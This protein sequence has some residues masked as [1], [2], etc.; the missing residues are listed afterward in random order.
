MQRQR[1]FSA[2][3]VILVVVGLVLFLRGDNEEVG[4]LGEGEEFLV[5]DVVSELSS[6][7]GVS[8]PEDVERISLSDVSGGTGTGL[9]TRKFD[10]GP[11]IH[12]V[13]A[14]LPDLSSGTF[15]EGWLVRGEVG[16]EDYSVL[17]TG[18]LRQSKGGYLLEFSSSQD[19]SDHSQVVV[20][21]ESMDDGEPETHILEGS[22]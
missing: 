11:F 19:L 6:Q 5:G 16:D 8:V 18:K 15:Y 1:L 2:L 20:T 21:V 13:L 14:A 4:Q 7:L 10:G 3:I 22:F 12:S 17:S 9:A